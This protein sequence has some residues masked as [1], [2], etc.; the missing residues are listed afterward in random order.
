MVECSQYQCRIPG[1]W[2]PSLRIMRHNWRWCGLGLT[3]DKCCWL[4][5]SYLSAIFVLVCICFNR[6][7]VLLPLTAFASKCNPIF[8][9]PVHCTSAAIYISMPALPVTCYWLL[10]QVGGFYLPLILVILWRPRLWSICGGCCHIAVIG[11][12][13]PLQVYDSNVD[14]VGSQWSIRCSDF[15]H[16]GDCLKIIPHCIWVY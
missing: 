7:Q 1:I 4:V 10:S 6:S 13:W 12:F 14:V 8:L 3:F 2:L 16:S 11:K 15:W 5:D 9:T